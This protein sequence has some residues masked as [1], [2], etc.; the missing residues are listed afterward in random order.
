[1]QQQLETA[2]NE[3]RAI[4][5]ES[6]QRKRSAASKMAQLSQIVQELAH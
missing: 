3:M 4:L 2:E 6:E 1:M 5:Q